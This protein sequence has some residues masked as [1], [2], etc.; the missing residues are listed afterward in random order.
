MTTQNQVQ[1][2][3]AFLASCETTDPKLAALL[4]SKLP[5]EPYQSSLIRVL[6]NSGNY[7]LVK[8]YLLR[9]FYFVEYSGWHHYDART[10]SFRHLRTL[11]EIVCS[12]DKGKHTYE[13]NEGRKQTITFSAPKF[14][15]EEV[16]SIHYHY[17]AEVGSQQQVDF[18][19][20][21]I[22]VVPPLLHR[23]APTKELLGANPDLQQ[24]LDT[25]LR[26][27]TI[28]PHRS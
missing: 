21:A 23:A 15:K 25:I 9:Y 22:N 18:A 24:H 11:D 10:K 27:R 8:Q 5:S 4:P 20:R 26:H 17:V 19:N 14:L 16:Q 28:C 12:G 3:D 13:D 7:R 1:D 6:I 2:L